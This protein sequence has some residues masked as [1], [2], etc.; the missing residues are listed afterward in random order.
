MTSISEQ[1]LDSHPTVTLGL[2]KDVFLECLEACL[3]CA[4]AC[5]LCAD[6]CLGEESGGELTQ[7]IRLDQDCVSVCTATVEIL[8]RHTGRSDLAAMR[9]L[10][11]ACRLACQA[12]ADE[13][14]THAAHHE[15]CRISAGACQRCATACN[16]LL[17]ALD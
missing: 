17:T 14:E 9:A 12:C 4:Q 2:R 10:L 15:H 3:D 13:C 1:M 8:S 16:A 6:A 5:A 11:E 7:C